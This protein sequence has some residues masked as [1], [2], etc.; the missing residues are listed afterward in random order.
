MNTTTCD[1][2]GEEYGI[3]DWPLCKSKANPMGHT[4]PLE[5]F[6]F[7][8]FVDVNMAPYPIEITSRGQ[9]WREMKKHKVDF[10]ANEVGLPGCEV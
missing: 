5:Y 3:G 2:C 9:L 4:P 8:P 7:K 1:E 10:M 6:P